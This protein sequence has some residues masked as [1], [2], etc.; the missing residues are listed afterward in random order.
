MTSNDNIR[1]KNTAPSNLMKS[2][3]KSKIMPSV[4]LMPTKIA[5]ALRPP[6]DNKAMKRQ[7][8]NL[9]LEN[10]EQIIMTPL[11][12]SLLAKDFFHLLSKQGATHLLD[13]INQ[14]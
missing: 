10:N 3:P 5:P 2:G 12:R 1:N 6:Q 9:Y 14:G 4:P 11:Y 7:S 13:E 8:N